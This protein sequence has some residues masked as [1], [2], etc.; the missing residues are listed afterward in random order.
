MKQISDRPLNSS[1]TKAYNRKLILSGIHKKPVS[2]A[3]LARETGLTR[4]AV[5]IIIDEL[6]KNGIIYE[7]ES[8][9]TGVGRTSVIL[10]IVPDSYFALGLNISRQGCSAGIAGLAGNVIAGKNIDLSVYD[11]V[12]SIFPVLL[13]EIRSMIDAAG[14]KKNKLLGMGICTPGPVDAVN[15]RIL[16]PPNFDLWHDVRIVS[17]L[18]NEFVDKIML[19]NYSSG[20]ALSEKNFGLG[21]NMDS[22]I[23]IVVDSGIGSGVVINK[24]LYKGAC[25]TGTEIGHITVSN[26]GKRCACANYGCLEL[27]A[28]IPEIIKEA[29]RCGCDVTRWSELVDN[30]ENGDN[31]CVRMLEK[32]AEVL[33]SGIINAVNILDIKDVILTGDVCYRSELLLNKIRQ[34][35]NMRIM[36]KHFKEIYIHISEVTEDIGILSAASIIIDDYLYRI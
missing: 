30:A 31:C 12:R 1:Y 6:I 36:K 32:E 3:Q 23:L 35:T 2:R 25:G 29:N 24:R 11:D 28:S 20:L 34:N 4:A 18:G 22:F 19:E 16:N 10:D 17:Q 14:I 27:Y 15:G 8:V 7:K 13:H 21:K 26:D 5:T 33:S 9:S